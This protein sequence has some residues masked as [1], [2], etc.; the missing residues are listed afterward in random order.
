MASCE[1]CDGSGDVHRADG[2]WLGECPICHP[3]VVNFGKR[4]YN[5]FVILNETDISRAMKEAFNRLQA[6]FSVSIEKLP[7][8][9][10]ARIVP[11][12]WGYPDRVVVVFDPWVRS[13]PRA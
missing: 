4:V 9:T 11:A 1:Y 2:E 6:Q 12:S 10:D 7:I 13:L 8:R 3:R 5:G